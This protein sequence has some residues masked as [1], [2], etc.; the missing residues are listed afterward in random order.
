MLPA[1]EDSLSSA[2]ARCF[3]NRIALKIQVNAGE[4]EEVF[5]PRLSQLAASKAGFTRTSEHFERRAI[6][7]QVNEVF[8]ATDDVISDAA[9]IL[10][11]LD[12][13]HLYPFWLDN[14]R[15][16]HLRVEAG[17]TAT[18]TAGEAA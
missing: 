3:P 9:P 14:M 12:P 18:F 8:D 10:K 16:A 5:G 1:I 11:R 17:A 4:L 2:L 7:A 15:D 6:G 13:L